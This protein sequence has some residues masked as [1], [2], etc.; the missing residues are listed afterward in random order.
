MEMVSQETVGESIC[1]LLNVFRIEI[2]EIAV[3]VFF[4]E[5]ILTVITTVI[6]VVSFPVL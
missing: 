4:D 1:D 6:D 2:H 5:D 3:V